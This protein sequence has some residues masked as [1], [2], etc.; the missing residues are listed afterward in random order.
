MFVLPLIF[1]IVIAFF[2]WLAYKM[3]CKQ[4]RENLLKKYGDINIVE[5]IMKKMV[6]QGQLEC[7]LI[8]SIG[9]PACIDEKVYKSEIKKTYKYKKSGKRIFLL[10]V[11]VENGMVVGWDGELQPPEGGGFNLRLESRLSC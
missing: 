4:K 1:M 3:N 8:D 2:V 10:R 5:K 6:W 9:R 7:E 11:N